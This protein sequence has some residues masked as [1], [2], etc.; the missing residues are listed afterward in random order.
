MNL[1]D[2]DSITLRQAD[3]GADAANTLTEIVDA[4]DSSDD[5]I[6]CIPKVMQVRS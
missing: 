3:G 1:L 5:E 6:R 4:A 2:G